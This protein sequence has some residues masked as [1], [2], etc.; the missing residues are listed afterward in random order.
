MENE[1]NNDLTLMTVNLHSRAL[2]GSRPVKKNT[3]IEQ[4]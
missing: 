4:L 2:A 3:K 1:V